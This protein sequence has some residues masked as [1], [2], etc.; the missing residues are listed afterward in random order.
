MSF[1]K[2]FQFLYHQA[3]ITSILVVI[4]V[5]WFIIS[6]ILDMRGLS[7]FSQSKFLIDWGADV[8]QLTFSGEYWRLFT[9]IFMHVGLAHLAMNML[10]LWSIGVILER[11]IPPLAFVGIYLLSGLFGSLASDVATIHINVISCGASG[12]I[13]GI[14]TALLAYSLIN[15]T[16]LQEMPIKSIVVSLLLTAGLGLLPSI[17]NMAHI[18]GAITG[19][20]LGGLITLC[21][22][23]FRYQ[24]QICTILTVLIFATASLILYWGYQH[25][26]Y[27][28][29]IN[30]YR[31]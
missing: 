11:L 16:D 31:Y 9:N 14:I 5:A 17:D 24:S 19:F 12:A 30:G 20:I 10:A 25:Y 3:K 6:R 21:L 7:D 13:L 23:K 26:Q 2:Y 27:D 29:L 18:G 4:N 22:K 8:A 1:L 15:R 28:Y